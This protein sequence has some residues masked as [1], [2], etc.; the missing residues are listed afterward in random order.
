MSDEGQRPSGGSAHGLSLAGDAWQLYRGPL[1]DAGSSVMPDV[2]GL[3]AYGRVQVP[4]SIQ[5]QAGLPDLWNDTPEAT[6]LNFDEWTYVR[7][8]EVDADPGART[9]LECDGLDYFADVWVDGT[10]V[11]HHEGMFST[12]EFDVTDALGAGPDHELVIAL[13]CPWRVDDRQFFLQPSGVGTVWIKNTE[14]MKGNLL[15]YWDG[16][17]LSGNAVFPFGLWGDVRIAVRSGVLL[18][19]IATATLEVGHDGAVVELACEWWSSGDDTGERTVS[20]EVAPDNFEGPPQTHAIRVDGLAPGTSETRHRFV[21]ADPVLWW[22]WDTGLPNLYRVTATDHATR[23][24]AVTRLGIRTLS[25][26]DRDRAY[27]LNG[28]RLF[29]RGVWYPFADIYPSSPVE[30]EQRRDVDMLVDANINHIIVFTYVEKVALYDACDERGILIFQELPFH[31]L[32]PMKVLEPGYPRYQRFWDWSLGEVRNIVRQRRGH[33]S[34]VTWCPFAET[35]KDGE[36]MWGADYTEYVLAIEAI[37]RHE[38]PDTMYHRSFCDFDESHIWNGGFAYGEFWDHY[39]HD[40]TFVSEF[41]AISLPVVETLREYMPDGSLWDRPELAEGRLRLP[42]DAEE[43]AFRFSFDYPGL[44]TIVWRMYHWADRHPASLDRFVDAVQWYQAM[45]LR[46]AAEAYRRNRYDQIVGCRT[47]SYRENLPGAHFTVVDHRQRP[48]QGYFGLAAAYEPVLL[49]LDDQ[50]PLRPRAAGGRYQHELLVIND[51]PTPRSLDV[52]AAL[53]RPDGSVVASVRSHVLVQ[54]D[55]SAS[56]GSLDLPLPADVAE[57]VLL[58]LAATGED[59]ALVTSA[60]TWIGVVPP[61]FAPTLRVLL[62]GNQRY[63]EPIRAAL[64]EVSGVVLSVVDEHVRVPRD[65]SW[66]E[67]LAARYDVIWFSGWDAAVHVFRPAELQAIADAVAAGVGFVHTGGQGSFHAADGRGAQLDL[68]ALGAALP[69]TMGP[70]EGAW[71][72]IP[73]ARMDPGSDPSF[74]FGLDQMAMLGYSRA[75]ATPGSTVHWWIGGHPLLVTGRH[76]SGRTVAFTGYLTPPIGVVPTTEDVVL[77]VTGAVD[78]PWLTS[79]IHA[80]G[81]YP[82][83]LLELSLSLLAAA[84]GRSM[85]TERVAEAYRQ[86][87]YERLTALPPTTL[88]LEVL[89]D[90]NDVADDRRGSVRVSNTGPVVARLVRGRITSRT[91]VDHRFRDGFADIL[92]GG[93]VDLR[94]E[95]GRDVEDPVIEISGQNTELVSKALDAVIH[96]RH[97]DPVIE[98]PEAHP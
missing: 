29:L 41:G 89:A 26:D 61:A 32:G 38:S 91:G 83:Q 3:R 94:F 35:L 8:F 9:F 76:G 69:V 40:S 5:A 45:G 87:L 60:D 97:R 30:S 67:D 20:V 75:A 63:N 6:S 15:H 93:S 17:P 37:V 74:G 66:A 70:H 33:P 44:A 22:S 51:T 7:R 88:A 79:D 59:G 95:V 34:V 49:T 58:R 71:D 25:R 78:P 13:S 84:A 21:V 80:Y 2:S 64:E 24:R 12:S 4:G 48:K 56:G 86:P 31:Q 36:W 46:Y 90:A 96:T 72:L 27:Y 55:A 11:G 53:H 18:R 39:D 62:L 14:Y 81:P 54:G 42:I 68:T 98:R 57:P 73:A 28:Q 65:S 52:A 92:P 82:A 77:D 10:W 1:R 47:W 43:Y 50:Y 23:S 85:E 16:L 19:R